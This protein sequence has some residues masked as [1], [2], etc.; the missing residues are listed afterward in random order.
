VPGISRTPSSYLAPVAAVFLALGDAEGALEWLERSY[1]QKNPSLR[2]INRT[3]YRRLEGNP[4]FVDLLRRV[5]LP[6]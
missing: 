4:R 5:G 6:Q 1:Q 2:F 3:H